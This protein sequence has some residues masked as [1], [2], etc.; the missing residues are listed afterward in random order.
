[1]AS[2]R[3]QFRTSDV[4]RPT[5]AGPLDV[6]QACEIALR[7]GKSGALATVF[8]THG[9]TPSSPGQKLFRCEDGVCIGSV[10]GG[11]IEREVLARLAHLREARVEEFRLGPELGMCC[12]GRVEVFLEPMQGQTDVL[13]VGAGHVGL[14]LARLLPRLG[15]RVVVTDSREAYIAPLEAEF[16]CV[17][18]EPSEAKAKIS[19]SALVLV[20]T[21]DHGLDQDAIEWAVRAGYPFVGGIGSRAKAER[22]RAR[23]LAKG[24]SETDVAR[25]RMPLGLAIGARAPDEI[26][27]AVAAELIQNRTV[28]RAAFVE[29]SK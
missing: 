26:A 13:L 3:S 25:I 29:H 4:P 27:I 8:R 18:G 6:L 14:A 15:F 16:S 7:A 22:T 10:G 19:A 17:C 20:M 5:S 11:A 28:T 2:E 9:S 23:L 24:F 1:M 21:H 12:G